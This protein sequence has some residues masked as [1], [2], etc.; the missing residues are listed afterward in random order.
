MLTSKPIV[1]DYITLYET[2][3]FFTNYPQYKHANIA[4]FILV[5]QLERYWTNEVCKVEM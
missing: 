2:L 4:N 3:G 5:V 1:H